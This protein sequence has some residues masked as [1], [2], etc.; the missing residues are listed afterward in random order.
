M[1]KQQQQQ[2]IQQ[3]SAQTSINE[4][5][6]SA[7][8]LS[9]Y[10][11][12]T[13]TTFLRSMIVGVALVCLCIQKFVSSKSLDVPIPDM[14]IPVTSANLFRHACPRN[15]YSSFCFHLKENL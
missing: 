13:H 11:G 3:K 7:S 10:D 4:R 2:E 5:D 6:R 9:L 14:L 15:Q 8:D 12:N 1:K